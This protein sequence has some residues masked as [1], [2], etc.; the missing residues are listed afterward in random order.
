MTDVHLCWNSPSRANHPIWGWCPGA[1]PIPP[2]WRGR[3]ARLAGWRPGHRYSRPARPPEHHPT[4]LLEEQT[5]IPCRSSFRAGF[6]EPGMSGC[7]PDRKA[8]PPSR[9][10]RT[11][12][13]HGQTPCPFDSACSDTERSFRIHRRSEIRR[14]RT[15]RSRKWS[16][17]CR[18]THVRLDAEARPRVDFPGQGWPAGPAFKA[19]EMPFKQ[20]GQSATDPVNNGMS[21]YSLKLSVLTNSKK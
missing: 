10:T 11:D 8:T 4:E 15:D 12:W 2:C 9:S 17:S 21:T 7:D 18:Y 16:R 20:I 13:P 3:Y 14:H 5:R 19:H 6:R 1:H